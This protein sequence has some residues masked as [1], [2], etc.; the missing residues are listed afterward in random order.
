MATAKKNEE[1]K[2]VKEVAESVT[3]KAAP[4]KTAPKKEAKTTETPVEAVAEETP[5]EAPVKKATAKAGKRSEKAI[6]EVEAKEAK[7]ERKATA[8]T[9]EEKPKAPAP[10]TRSLLERRGKK[11]QESAK[12][13][14][15]DKEY[16]LVEALAI[17]T[18]TSPVKF[19]ATVE[20]HVRLNVDPRHADQ[21]IRG[22]LV[23]PAGT[24]RNVRVAVF[25][26]T[27]DAAKAKKAGADI[28]GLEEITNA[29]DKGNID[30]DVL[31]SS[32]MMMAKLGKYARLLGPRG[33]MP[34]PKSG[35][36]TTNV[37][38]AV[39]EAKAGRVEFRVDSTGIV[40][41][42]IGKVSF[43]EKKLQDNANAVIASIKAAKPASVKGNYV[44]TMFITTTM[45]P[46]IKV[47]AQ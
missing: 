16:S 15:N 34:N 12:L 41:L 24:G 21:N 7:E 38:K 44:K 47:A 22:N 36:V 23:L 14:E 18:K 4:K 19:D 10:K 28:A 13:V 6:K 9:E 27:E 2:E 29:L 8:K 26:D 46:S 43:G 37:V 32:P 30:F 1:I 45:G 25:A 40:H 17:A 3:K 42:G 39:E 33:L 20:M 5:A 35:T 11:F 31:V